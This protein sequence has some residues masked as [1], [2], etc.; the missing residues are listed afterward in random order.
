[1]NK[2]YVLKLD[3]DGVKIITKGLCAL[4]KSIN[5]EEIDVSSLDDMILKLTVMIDQKK[6]YLPLYER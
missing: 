5:A 3:L 6:R 1:M 4:R 2:K